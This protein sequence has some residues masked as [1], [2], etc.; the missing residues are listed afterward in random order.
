M[1]HRVAVLTHAQ[2]V[3]DLGRILDALLAVASVAPKLRAQLVDTAAS[4][5]KLLAQQR[6]RCRGTS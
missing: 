3:H 6:A 4:I 2:A 5:V 1:D